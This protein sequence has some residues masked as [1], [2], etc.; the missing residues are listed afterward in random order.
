MIVRSP[1]DFLK[2]LNAGQFPA[3]APA[4]PR[5]VFMVE[6]EGFS[7]ST[8]SAVD[9]VY[10]N[11]HSEADPQRALAQSRALT[12]ALRRA[13][14]SVRVFP[15]MADAPDGVFPNNVFAT[16]PGRLIIGNMY[17]PGRRLEAAR[18]DIRA[19]FQV[20]GYTLADL[21]QQPCIAELTGPL[22]LDRARKI[23]FCG[24][25][26]RVDEAGLAAMHEAFDLRLSF[27]FDLLASEYHTNVV[28]SVLAGRACVICPESFTD[29][30]VPEAI[31]RAF[32][33]RTL[34]LSEAEKNAFAGNCIALTDKHL[35]MSETGRRALDP[36]RLQTLQGWGFELCSV[37]LDE[38]EKAGGSLRCMVAEIF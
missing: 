12:E 4:L 28:M 11:L 25:T 18:E 6:P 37:E 29:A 7:V 9:N 38:I 20:R 33:G 2:Q 13:G 5:A 34:M 14:V 32:P 22:I 23:G 17:H 24:M 36:E 21:S 16:I 27:G 3:D 26:E 30:A 19:H 35:F 31:S 8:E 10:M 15:G 1:G